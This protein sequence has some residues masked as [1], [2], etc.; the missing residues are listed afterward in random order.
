MKTPHPVIWK[1]NIEKEVPPRN[2]DPQKRANTNKL[3]LVLENNLDLL[4]DL[5]RHAID[6]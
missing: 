2:H 3:E 4:V 5:Y 6:H 1:E